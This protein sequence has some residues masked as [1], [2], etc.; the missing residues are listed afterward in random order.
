M[1]CVNHSF[2][3]FITT[4]RQ[5]QSKREIMKYSIQP[6]IHQS[7]RGPAITW[8][9]DFSCSMRIVYFVLLLCERTSTRRA[10]KSAS[11]CNFCSTSDVCQRFFQILRRSSPIHLLGSMVYDSCVTRSHDPFA[12]GLKSGRLWSDTYT[13]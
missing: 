3:T 8:R 4:Q 2:F 6:T 5:Q 12:A 1:H 9:G 13:E 10:K 7:E 11:V